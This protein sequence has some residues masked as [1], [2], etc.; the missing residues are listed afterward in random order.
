VVSEDVTCYGL[1]V[2]LR[3]LDLTAQRISMCCAVRLWQ[4]HSAA[5]EFTHACSNDISL[6]QG[7]L[8]RARHD[9]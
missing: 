8:A 9:V 2:R 3:R 7:L 4:S 5:D 6:M 1:A